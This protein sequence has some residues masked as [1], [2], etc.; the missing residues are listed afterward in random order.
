MTFALAT[1]GLG[2]PQVAGVVVGLVL[3]I[4]W[5]RAAPR[6]ARW[7][8][9]ASLIELVLVAGDLLLLGSADLFSSVTFGTLQTLD[10]ISDVLMLLSILAL[11]PLLYAVQL[12]RNLRV[13]TPGRH[14]QPPAS[15]LPPRTRSRW[16]EVLPPP[17]DQD[18]PS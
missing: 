17:G 12:D 9:V 14:P 13:P 3:S 7:A 6:A 16:E 15:Q 18:H 5:R 2:L 11:G 8:L 4:R 10:S 1:V